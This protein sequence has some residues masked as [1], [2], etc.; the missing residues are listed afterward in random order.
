MSAVRCCH[1]GL[2]TCKVPEANTS[3]Q[4]YGI[5]QPC[6]RTTSVCPCAVYHS[7]YE[8]FRAAMASDINVCSVLEQAVWNSDPRYLRDL[9]DTGLVQQCHLWNNMFSRAM[10]IPEN[11]EMLIDA[12]FTLPDTNTT[13][14]W[15][16][17]ESIDGARGVFDRVIQIYGADRVRS[18]FTNSGVFWVDYA[19]HQ[20]H[21]TPTD[22][23]YNI[24]CIASLVNIGCDPHT[25]CQPHD[26]K[27][28]SLPT[29]IERLECSADQK[30]RLCD[31]VNGGGAVA[32]AANVREA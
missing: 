26:I 28:C 24:E 27:P 23:D 30:Q 11:F 10:Y 29:K 31:V 9:L 2:E 15:T 17:L 21:R 12:G 6:Q 25:L 32:K 7:H 14:T 4:K 1:T 8:C 20:K 3:L 13:I 16:V 19:V 18:A 5:D 22:F